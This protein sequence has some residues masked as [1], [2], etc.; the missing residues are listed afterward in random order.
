MIDEQRLSSKEQEA[1]AAARAAR[2]RAY[3]PYSG[4][5]VGAAVI[6]ESGAI[7]A[8]CNMENETSELWVCAERNAIAA[9]VANG[10]RRF[11]TIVVI[12][13]DRRY[14]PPC[15]SCRQVIAEFSPAAGIIMC[16][17]SGIVHRANLGDLGSI[18]F[19]KP[20]SGAQP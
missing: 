14:W 3:A 11:R 18:P 5:Q 16:N 6:T 12:A 9:A 19:T 7:F 20:E 2:K 10:E 4:K 8:S 13:P 17:G 1:L 15:R